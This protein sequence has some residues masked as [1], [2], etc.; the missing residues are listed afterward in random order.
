MDHNAFR[1]KTNGS[2]MVKV[3]TKH[4]RN[5][6]TYYHAYGFAWYICFYF[7]FFIIYLFISWDLE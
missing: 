6:W 2:F 7:L 5:S 3:F 1:E 4:P